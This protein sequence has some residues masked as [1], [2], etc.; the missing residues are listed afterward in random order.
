M[1]DAL[2]I[3]LDRKSPI[4]LYHQV[5]E[6]FEGAIREG[7]LPAGTK[8][9]NEIDLAKRYNIS[10]PTLRQAMDK[11]VREGLIVRR[12]GVGTQVVD[13][14]IRRDLKLS[15]LYDD[16]RKFGGTPRTVV[17]TL[18]T[19]A[20]SESVSGILGIDAGDLVYHL[21]R[22]RSID[23]EPLGIMENYLPLSI[24]DITAEELQQ[25][26]LYNVMRNR[27]SLI[28][29][30]RQVVGAS[31]ASAE[32]ARLLDINSG[33][34]LVT[35]QRT[36]LDSSGTVVEYGNHVYRGDLYTYETT[37]TSE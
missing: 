8:L 28:H 11:M 2:E 24:G 3:H 23:R 18:E 14:R 1:A 37:L 25:D 10:R 20:A 12:R 34:A 9:D 32:Q 7:K 6:A 4:P 15:S 22:L 16:L 19:L 35:M 5:A 29:V 26:G 21:R 31:V 36:S 27:G 33:D 17:L 13:K 30:A